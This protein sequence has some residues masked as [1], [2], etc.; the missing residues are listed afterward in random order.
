[1]PTNKII[2]LTNVAL[3]GITLASKSLLIFFL[4]RFLEPAELGLYG[5]LTATIGYA[6]YLLSFDFYTFSMREILKFERYEWGGLIKNQGALTIV[7][8]AIFLPLLSLIFLNGLLPWSVAGWFFVLLILEHL[9]GEIIRLLTFISEQLLASLIL[10]LRSGLWAVA[11]SAI[12]FIDPN[13]RQLDYILGAWS[14]GG[15]AALLL[16][17]YRLHQLKITGWH[18]NV[19][20]SWIISGLKIAVP[21]LVATLAIRGIFTLDRYW[22]E[23]LAGSE[24]LGAYV[25]F[26]ALSNVIMSFLDAGVFAFINPSLVTAWRKQDSLAFTQQ[27]KK[28]LF[29]T[30]LISTSLAAIALTMIAPLLTL[31]NKPLYLAHKNLFPWILLATMLYIFGL[32]PHAALYAQRLDR[33]IIQSHIASLICFIPATWMFSIIWPNVAV[34][35]GLCSSFAL[36]L[37][38]KSWAYFALTPTQYRLFKS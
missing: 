11:I 34:P 15:I 31:L 5:L 6:L 13:S 20:W 36:I 24:I 7:L 12:M 19:D 35:L 26:M 27:V 17:I 28:L 8:Y 29:Q 16:G 14:I 10:F 23:A 22:F 2:R 4:A 9:T 3:R 18:K 32:I 1:M 25:L 21:F 30:V 38:W 33:P 37:L